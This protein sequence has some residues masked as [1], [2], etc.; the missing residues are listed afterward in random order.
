M[1]DLK[2]VNILVL[3]VI[4]TT[5]HNRI[6]PTT[7]RS[8]EAQEIRSNAILTNNIANAKQSTILVFINK[9]FIKLLLIPTLHVRK[10][11]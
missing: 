2:V 9:S 8:V 10:V 7:F 4:V 1:C 6:S 11:G 5:T 3:I